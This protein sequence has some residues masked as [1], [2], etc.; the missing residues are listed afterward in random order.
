MDAGDLAVK[1]FFQ[2]GSTDDGHATI[3]TH[4]KMAAVVVSDRERGVI[5]QPGLS[6]DGLKAAVPVT[7]ES[8]AAGPNPKRPIRV[9]RYCPDHIIGKTI[10]SGIGGEMVVCKTVK[11]SASGSN[12]VHAADFVLIN[13]EHMVIR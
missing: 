11:P 1:E 10:A 12:P 9:A 7:I 3:A 4:P 5:K 6:R 8:A 2:L 13:R